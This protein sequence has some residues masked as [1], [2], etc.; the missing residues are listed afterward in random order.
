V[1]TERIDRH[2]RAGRW[3]LPLLVVLALFAWLPLAVERFLPIT[4]LPE[5][6]AAIRVIADLLRGDP[7]AKAAWE[8]DL[9][10]SQ[11]L[12]YHFA[13]A[14]L[15]LVTG[16][17]TVANRILLALA[18]VGYPL[19]TASL[20]R[21]LGRDPRLAVFACMPFF[22]RALTIG[23]LPF[24]ASIP[25]A[26]YA[27]AIFVQQCRAP[28]RTRAA[29]LVLVGI[30]LF[31]LHV[32]AYTV[33]VLVSVVVSAIVRF[34]RER[35]G[36][37]QA[38]GGMARDLWVWIPS[39]AC[40]VHWSMEGSLEG[41]TGVLGG[42]N[43]ARM[44]LWRSVK[45]LPLWIHDPWPAKFDDAAG[46][47]WWIGILLVVF[48]NL[49]AF[50]KGG[51]REVLLL[52]APLAVGVALVLALPFR[53]GAA[54]MLNVRLATFV[55]LAVLLPL[56][57]PRGAWGAGA[58]ALGGAA[59]L[60]LSIG[61]ALHVHAARQA[62]LGDFGSL[63]DRMAPG[64]KVEELHF[65]MRSPAGYYTPWIH[66]AGYHVALHGGIAEWT[67]G[68]LAHWSVHLREGAAGPARPPFWDLNPCLFRNA[69]DGEWADWVLVEGD[70]DPF[71]GEPPGPRFERAA[72]SGRFVL[73]RRTDGTW[74]GDASADPGPCA[75][76]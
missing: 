30:A 12:L 14:L 44:A 15:A 70:T 47:L 1:T 73:Y 66:A 19:A 55:A 25:V 5:H 52:Y 24:C 18:A 29:L 76:M 48:T 53:V 28:S 72:R 9:G 38:A 51:P 17:A 3:L 61:S 49:G 27:L 71:A 42:E 4:D 63:V 54:G 36:L 37:L 40:A 34:P 74:T 75:P 7:V 57:A 22:G 6:E 45:G 59:T 33:T 41:P 67:F 10:R 26:L 60:I 2:P 11:Y 68:H 43:V 69:Q 64:Q 35:R 20:L 56:P 58:L 16:S 8:L 39:A 13:G 23:F 65:Q 31:Y 32:N 62:E 46:L 50:R 21:S